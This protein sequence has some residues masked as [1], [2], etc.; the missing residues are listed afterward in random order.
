[1]ISARE[2]LD[3][4]VAVANGPE[5]HLGRSARR[6]RRAIEAGTLYRTALDEASPDELREHLA[7]LGLI[8]EPT[9]L[10][11]TE[12]PP[13]HIEAILRKINPPAPAP[14]PPRKRAPHKIKPP[15]SAAPRPAKA[16]PPPPSGV[17]VYRYPDGT[18]F[19]GPYPIVRLN[20]GPG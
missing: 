6:F 14:K 17:R 2:F 12:P 5:I 9:S 4:V 10:E 11:L 19:W 8:T 3:L 16:L 1:M 7:S 18:G 15:G 13:P 20:P